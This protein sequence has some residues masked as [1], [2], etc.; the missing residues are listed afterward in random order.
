[1]SVEFTSQHLAVA[2]AAT[3]L[4]FVAGRAALSWRASGDALIKDNTASNG[5]RSVAAILV[6][7]CVLLVAVRAPS[8]TAAMT[9][10]V[11][12]AGLGYLA[13]IDARTHLVPVWPTLLLSAEP[14]GLASQRCKA[15]RSQA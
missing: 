4:T 11:F 13:L 14:L 2:L 3:A 7:A 8:A 1:M 15:P 12:A 5:R 10:A 6:S 9:N